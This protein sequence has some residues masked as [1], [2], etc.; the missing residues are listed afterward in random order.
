M[1]GFVE[2]KSWKA[3][4]PHLHN[5]YWVFFSFESEDN[6]HLP[7]SLMEILMTD[8]LYLS[9]VQRKL[10]F[11]TV[12]G[13]RTNSN[14]HTAKHNLVGQLGLN[15]LSSLAKLV[16]TTW[17]LI[18]ESYRV[19]IILCF[20]QYPGSQTAMGFESS[21]VRNNIQDRRKLWGLNHPL[22]CT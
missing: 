8:K 20:A 7:F 15:K 14:L 17:L 21:S 18:P 5:H 2:A 11:Q 13:Q 4:R 19:W 12:T 3:V 22:F 10:E 9:I 16:Q 1:E 6:T